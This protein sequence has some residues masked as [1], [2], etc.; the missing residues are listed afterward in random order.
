ML[1]EGVLLELAHDVLIES[2]S[3]LAAEACGVIATATRDLMR[4]QAQEMVFEQ[5]NDVTVAECI[6]T[7]E[8][9]TEGL[10]R[11]VRGGGRV[12]ARCG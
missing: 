4:G 10:D 12:A 5:Y 7:V 6:A 2:G 8:G 9:K 3:P 1:A 11:C